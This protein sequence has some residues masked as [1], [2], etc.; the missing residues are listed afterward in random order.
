MHA[1]GYMMVSVFQIRFSGLKVIRG[2]RVIEI[3]S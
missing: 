2:I 1:F 3:I